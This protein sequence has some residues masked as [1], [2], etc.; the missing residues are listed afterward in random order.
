MEFINWK[1]ASHPLNWVIVFLM[2]FIFLLGVHLV[3][4][5]TQR[6]K[7]NVPSPTAVNS[8]GY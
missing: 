5:F 2:V 1:L 8:G 6:P 3:V 7:P 4:D